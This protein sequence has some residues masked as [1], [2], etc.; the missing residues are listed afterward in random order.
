M[1]SLR[2]LL[3]E[4]EYDYILCKLSC[5]KYSDACVLSSLIFFNKK[6]TL[7]NSYSDR[8]WDLKIE[9]VIKNSVMVRDSNM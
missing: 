9:E 1:R 3:F 5:A 7:N 6:I 8:V 2:Q 4:T